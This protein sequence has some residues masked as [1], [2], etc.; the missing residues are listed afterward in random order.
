MSLALGT[1]ILPVTTF[2]SLP[3]VPI[4]FQILHQISSQTYS[5][6]IRHSGS[7]IGLAHG[8]HLHLKLVPSTSLAQNELLVYCHL[9]TLQGKLIPRCYGMVHFEGGTSGILLEPLWGIEI[10][11][12]QPPFPLSQSGC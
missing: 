9:K 3:S 7:H 2:P 10:E 6:R 8:S 12:R 5:L 11:N 1:H 4:K